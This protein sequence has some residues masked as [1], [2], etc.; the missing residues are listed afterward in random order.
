[1]LK[2]K[3]VQS[4]GITFL[5]VVMDILKQDSVKYTTSAVDFGKDSVLL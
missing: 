3:Q 2:R 1:M 5:K 4:H